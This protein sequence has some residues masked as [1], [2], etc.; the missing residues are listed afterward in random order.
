MGNAI[1]AEVEGNENIRKLAGYISLYFGLIGN[2]A[3][4]ILRLCLAGRSV[5]SGD[6]GVANLDYRDFRQ[7][8]RNGKVCVDYRHVLPVLVRV[9][10]LLFSGPA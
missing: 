9:G 5:C 7:D 4:D 10:I 6:L 8:H 2:I 3:A 1:P